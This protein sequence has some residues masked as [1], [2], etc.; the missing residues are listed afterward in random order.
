MKKDKRRIAREMRNNPYRV[1]HQVA[2]YLPNTLNVTM[3]VGT[4]TKKFYRDKS[5][6]FI[7]DKREINSSNISEL[8]TKLYEKRKLN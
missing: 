6:R 8:V 7:I 2:Y 1:G 4:I 3:A 5:V